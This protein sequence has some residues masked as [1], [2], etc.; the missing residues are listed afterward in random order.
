MVM[1]NIWIWLNSRTYWFQILMG[2]S[3]AGIENK[4]AVNAPKWCDSGFVRCL[5]LGC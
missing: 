2:L 3:I 1:L 5:K 4:K